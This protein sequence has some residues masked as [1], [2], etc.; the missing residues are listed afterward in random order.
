M[1]DFA[2]ARDWNQFHSAKNLAVA[3]SVEAGELLEHFQ[4]ISDK[5]S[6]SFPNEKIDK[7]EAEIADVL[8]C[9]V[10]LADILD[11]N[12]MKAAMAKIDTNAQKYPVDKSRG[13]ARKYSDL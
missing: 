11:I 3:L 12:L 5:E 4:W 1:R 13:S 6:L 10:R 9:L 7:V 8:L 2:E